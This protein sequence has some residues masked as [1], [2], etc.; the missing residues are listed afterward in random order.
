[1]KFISKLSLILMLLFIITCCSSSKENNAKDT[2]LY[3]NKELG[4]S[5]EVPSIVSDKV[6]FV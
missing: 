3:G 2:F 1:M 6:S 5:M 4:F